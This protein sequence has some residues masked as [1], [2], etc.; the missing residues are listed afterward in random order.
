MEMKSLGRTKDV[1]SLTGLITALSRFISKSTDKCVP[2]FNLLRGSEK[3]EWVEECEQAFQKIKKH[4]A[5]PPGLSKL[6]DG[7]D[8]FIYLAITEHAISAALIREEEKVQHPVYYVNKWLVGAESRIHDIPDETENVAGQRK[9]FPAWQLYV[10][11][12]SNEHHAR[13]GLI[14]ITPKQH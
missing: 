6:V 8:L 5:Q 12:S 9:V 13:A 1:Q 11:R 10:D 14:L 7:E 2:F 4:L 3:F